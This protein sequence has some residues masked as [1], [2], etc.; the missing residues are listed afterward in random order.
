MQVLSFTLS[1]FSFLG[2]S[3]S[4]SIIY[5]IFVFFIFGYHGVCRSASYLKF[6]PSPYLLSSFPLK[7]LSEDWRDLGS[8]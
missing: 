2:V 1:C 8:R 4:Y 6:C 7:L 3:L 5:F